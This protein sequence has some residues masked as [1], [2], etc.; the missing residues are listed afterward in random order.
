MGKLWIFSPY[1][2]H[3]MP[4]VNR[5]IKV[6]IEMSLALFLLKILNTCGNIAK[7]LITPT[8]VAKFS[9]QIFNII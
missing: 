9:S 7:E 2:I 8:E 4:A 1:R 5:K 3:I 6:V